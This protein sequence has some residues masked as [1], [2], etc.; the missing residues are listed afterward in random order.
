V[1]RPL[2]VVNGVVTTRHLLLYA[3]L[4]C[5]EFGLRVYVRCW[6]RC[7]RGWKSATFLECVAEAE[8]SPGDADSDVR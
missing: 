7:L 3:P 8:R 4:I 6:S 2:T 5:R 1:L